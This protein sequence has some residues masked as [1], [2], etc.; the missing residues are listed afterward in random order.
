MRPPEVR[1]RRH[2]P[3]EQSPIV[4]WFRRAS[5]IMRWGVLVAIVG[6]GAAAIVAVGTA[7]LITL[8]E[9]SV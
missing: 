8:V 4:A 2:I 3:M 9:N 6:V 1:G 5:A 7:I